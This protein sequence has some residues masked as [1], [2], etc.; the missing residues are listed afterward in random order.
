MVK[1]P[2]NRDDHSTGVKTTVSK[3]GVIF[4]TLFRHHWWEVSVLTTAPSL[5]PHE[6]G[7]RGW[8][9]GVNSTSSD[10]INWIYLICNHTNLPQ[11]IN[12][13]RLKEDE[14]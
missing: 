2:L 4:G 12:S 10:A 11:H 13:W 9:G 5:L 7:I 14:R 6:K 8:G 3:G 1:Q